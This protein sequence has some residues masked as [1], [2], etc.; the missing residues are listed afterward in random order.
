VFAALS[1][2]RLA[3]VAVLAALLIIL[4]VRRSASLWIGVVAALPLVVFLSGPTVAQIWKG[5]AS[6]YLSADSGA[7]RTLLTL[8][9]FDVAGGHFPFG[10][11]FGRYGSFVAG[12]DY[13]PEYYRLGFDHV[14]GL[15]PTP[16]YNE[17]LNDTFWPAVLGEGGYIGAVCYLAA[18]LAVFRLALRLY[19]TGSGAART[20]ALMTF[21]V[22]IGMLILSPGGAVLNTG[23]VFVLPCLLLGVLCR[24]ASVGGPENS[25]GATA[26]GTPREGAGGSQVLQGRTVPGGA[27]RAAA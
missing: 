19:R 18:V 20:V 6:Q 9:A 27:G 11:G 4:V 16:P 8:R 2:R 1:S 13:S 14:Y 3:V 7:A 24:L 10:A 21:T 12:A 5:T 22:W 23:D 26:A 25:R 15:M 17:F